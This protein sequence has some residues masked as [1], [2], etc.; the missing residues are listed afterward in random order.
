MIESI[1]EKNRRLGRRSEERSPHKSPPRQT[2][3]P[4]HR[5]TELHDSPAHEPEYVPRNNTMPPPLRAPSLHTRGASPNGLRRTPSIDMSKDRLPPPPSIHQSS[6]VSRTTSFSRTASPPPGRYIPPQRP[7]EYSPRDVRPQYLPY[8]EPISAPARPRPVVSSPPRGSPPREPSAPRAVDRQAMESYSN[9]F[10]RNEARSFDLRPTS[11]SSIFPDRSRDGGSFS[12]DREDTWSHSARGLPRAPLPR[13]SPPRHGA[14][15]EHTSFGSSSL[16]ANPS[17]GYRSQTAPDPPSTARYTPYDP[18]ARRPSDG[19]W[20]S[21]DWDA[22][23]PPENKPK[24]LDRFTIEPTWSRN[25]RDPRDEY[26]PRSDRDRDRDRDDFGPRPRERDGFRREPSPGYADG[27]R[28]GF[29]RPSDIE[30]GM[31]PM[32]RSRPDDGYDPRAGPGPERGRFDLDARPPV[33]EYYPHEPV[34]RPDDEYIPRT[35]PPYNSWNGP[36]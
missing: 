31:R 27:L 13:D 14:N 26:V 32:K 19:P 3:G 15:R 25:E 8:D 7:R 12:M 33:G 23:R 22:S 16:P 28:S 24:L 21:H 34:R 18:P 20:P 29:R 2:D 36:P 10:P 5:G 1:E 9:S 30:G 4:P 6:R 35:R 17:A 11:S